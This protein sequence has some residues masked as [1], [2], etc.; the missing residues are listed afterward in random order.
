M[1]RIYGRPAPEGVAAPTEPLAEWVVVPGDPREIA[2][3]CN[4]GARQYELLSAALFA[5]AMVSNF[6]LV[7]I[8]IG[9]LI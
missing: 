5:A 8:V 2:P 7:L 1:A 4:R 6:L 3:A 9:R